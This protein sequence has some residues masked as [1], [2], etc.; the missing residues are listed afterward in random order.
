M[1]KYILA[2]ISICYVSQLFANKQLPLKKSLN[3]KNTS[4]SK[5]AI[6][7]K[8]EFKKKSSSKQIIIEYG[9]TSWNQSSELIDTAYLFIRDKGSQKLLKVFLDE[10]APDSAIFKGVFSL[11]LESKR[12]YPEVFIPPQNSRDEKSAASFSRLLLNGKTRR[13][14]LF[15]R[16]ENGKQIIDVF[17]TR[18]QL[19]QAHRA[20]KEKIAAEK[21]QKSLVKSIAKKE[22]LAAQENVEKLSKVAE[23]K[24]IEAKMKAE[25]I[26]LKQI[27]EQKMKE[28]IE[29]EKLLAAKE[30]RLRIKKAKRIARLAENQFINGKFKLAQENFEKSIDLNPNDKSYY[31]KYAV[32]LYRNQK[33][34]KSLVIFRMIENDGENTILK[35]YYMGLIH[36]RLK[37]FKQAVGYLSTVKTSK[38]KLSP[39]AAFY[40]GVIHFYGEK[41]DASQNQFEFVLDHSKDPKLDQRAEEYI[42]NIAQQKQYALKQKQR[43]DISASIGY[44]QDSNILL[45]TDTAIDQGTATSINGGRLVLSSNYAYR[46]IYKKSH[47]F[48]LNYDLYYVYSINPA[49]SA[50]DPFINTLSTPYSFN[51]KLFGKGFSTTLTPG[52]EVLFM[53][54]TSGNDAN[55]SGVRENILNSIFVSSKNLFI[56]SPTW[57]SKYTLELRSEDSL[58]TS[59]TGD[60]DGDAL[61]ISFISEQS[62][63]FDNLKKNGL[64]N[65]V[66]II[67]NQAN[68]KKQTIY[69]I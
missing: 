23:E 35:K 16:V 44:M 2:L 63:F 57:F 64:V 33:I 56:M 34:N 38:D 36:Y 20:Y 6:V 55:G 31:F 15:F 54:G 68:G 17:D 21:A 14:P 29:A 48:S 12:V 5:Q 10:T 67:L 42:E 49:S 59:S 26:R 62:F 9:S 27:E 7:L 3:K 32:S 22:D 60:E 18:E 69:P 4:E 58:L 13:K 61:K 37:E 45:T 43:N 39:S 50:A 53:E 30:R 19:S 25:R 52:Y 41:W 51:T 8:K 65:T 40:L 24:L 11:S 66:S 47:S 28:R 46:A 1:G